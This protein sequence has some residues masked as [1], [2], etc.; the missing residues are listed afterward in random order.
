MLAPYLEIGEVLKPQGV[1]GLVKVR[2]DTDAPERF[3]EL[4]TVYIRSADGA[5]RP[6]SVGD[7]SVRDG[8]AYLRLD[9]A[10][11]RDE[12]EKQRGWLLYVDRA[13]AK[14]LGENEWYITDLVGCTVTL[15]SGEAV[16]RV[17]EVMQ[18]GAN[19]VFVIQGPR[20]EVLVPVLKDALAAV[21]VEARQIVLKAQRFREVAVLP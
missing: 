21:D 7:A 6:L 20:G 12:A 14:P 11:T 8:F 19:D 10:Q 17:T 9:G 1:R 5:F 3:S 2:P 15:D 13:H 4:N 18:P 16:G